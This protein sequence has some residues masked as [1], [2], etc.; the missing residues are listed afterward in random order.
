MAEKG[1][2]VKHIW[3]MVYFKNLSVADAVEHRG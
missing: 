2:E 3:V 1:F